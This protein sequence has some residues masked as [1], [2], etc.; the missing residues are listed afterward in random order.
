MV[1]ILALFFLLSLS[2][3]AESNHTTPSTPK[4]ERSAEKP[5]VE[6]PKQDHQLHN[7]LVSALQEKL[8]TLDDKL[9]DNIWLTRYSNYIT[10][11]KLKKTLL[12]YE[13]EIDELAKTYKTRV[14]NKKRLD[15]LAR[16]SATVEK[17][18]ELLK[19]YDTGSFSKLTEPDKL[20]EVPHIDNPI[21]I[22]EGLSYLKQL[23]ESKQQYADKVE[24]LSDILAQLKKKREYTYELSHIV[25]DNEQLINTLVIL[26]DEIKEFQET[27]DTA[28]TTH[29]L[30]SKKIAEESLKANQE[31]KQQ[32]KRII[33]IATFVFAAFVFAFILKMIS[34][35]YIADNE[36][37]YMTNKVI[38]FVNFAII[39][40]I[41]L[42]SFIEN[43]DYLVT[44]L[45]FASAGIAIAM[46]DLFMSM[47]G[48]F[49]IVLG[50]SIH[51]GDRVKVKK[52][53]VVYV[54]DVL[55]ISILRIT[56]HEDITLTS[57]MENR[58]SG[59]VIFIPNNYVFTSLISNYSH[60]GLKTV[61]DGIDINI[62]YD[63]NHK[64]AAHITKEVVKKYSKGYT[65]I[66]RKQLNKLRD[67]YSLRNTNVDPRVF[68]F[69]EPY[70]IRISSWYLT[71]AFA[72]LTL[73]STI[74]TEI[75]D[76]FLKEEDITLAYPTYSMSHNQPTGLPHLPQGSEENEPKGLF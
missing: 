57:Y 58:R 73:R 68:T 12:D 11:K 43:A 60:S 7:K 49:V 44:V 2:L 45:G 62:T 71:N 30:Y 75:L 63:S 6:K 29:S 53:G 1:R 24:A 18:L 74:S 66:T 32:M 17:Q 65:E 22:L 61:W 20:P 56:I 13:R 27:T 47:L 54:G 35:K 34:K 19:D 50:G 42:F 46:K 36:R 48:W 69:I 15:E 16:K 3:H 28:T 25:E 9:K 33:N 59:R 39:L 76:E 72:T 31:I 67:R 55:D 26:D 5:K 23:N 52:D 21:S 10:Y 70:G 64:K 40:L 38:N 14:K 8:D 41:V 51:V 4:V 37:Y